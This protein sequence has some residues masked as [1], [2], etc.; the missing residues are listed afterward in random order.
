MR[1]IPLFAGLGSERP[2]R[3]PPIRRTRDACVFGESKE[4]EETERRISR[5]GRSNCCLTTACL[6]EHRSR[7]FL[8]QI[9]LLLACS[10][11]L[12]GRPVVDVVARRMFRRHD[13]AAHR[14]ASCR[15]FI[16]P[17]DNPRRSAFRGVPLARDAQPWIRLRDN[18]SERT[19][20]V[21]TMPPSTLN[22]SGDVKPGADGVSDGPI[23]RRANRPC[24]G[25]RIDSAKV[26]W[27]DSSV[28]YGG[29]ERA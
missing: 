15:R 1:P 18:E 19:Q 23:R 12:R 22:W 28:T 13:F 21:S 2:R 29:G 25:S 11:G 20:R 7:N 8:P 9:K 4:S 27:R 26:R 10:S 6:D 17:E 14:W 3:R 16:W 5:I 24:A